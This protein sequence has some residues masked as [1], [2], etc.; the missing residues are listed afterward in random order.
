MTRFL[1]TRLDLSRLAAVKPDL[2]LTLDFEAILAARLAD[3]RTRMLAAGLDVDILGLETDPLVFLQQEDAYRQ[4]LDYGLLNDTVRGLLPAFSTGVDLDHIVLR[5]GV[6]R[7]STPATNSAPAWTEDDDTLRMRYFASFGA[8]SAGSEDAYIF[9]ALTAYPQAWHVF[10]AG[11]EEHGEP[12]RVDV[13]VTAPGGVQADL[14]TVI[15]INRA[16]NE[17]NVRPLTDYVNVV[18][19]E[20][21]LYTITMN[22]QILPGPD[23][24]LLRDQIV[25]SLLRIT[26]ERYR[27]GGEVPV[28]ALE[29]AAYQ[30]GA[31]SVSTTL[32]AAD[33]P[34]V[35]D[36]APYCSAITVVVTERPHD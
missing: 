33:I 13:V 7:L 30:L 11:P 1:S 17:K 8:P 26:G 24:V 36:R 28:S 6:V 32:P 4:L 5:A 2:V 34:R 16:L 29:S 12:G 14:D 15:K 25:A 3:L 27:G 18:A 31:V 21:L 35:V 23:P 10:C 20:P 22:V 19:A 9:A